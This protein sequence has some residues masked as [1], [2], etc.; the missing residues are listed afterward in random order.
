M[1]PEAQ[2]VKAA[3]EQPDTEKPE[4]TDP[5]KLGADDD[6]NDKTEAGPD[7]LAPGPAAD[8]KTTKT[9]KND[10]IDERKKKKM[11]KSGGEGDRQENPEEEMPSD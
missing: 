8:D 10:V 4:E 9:N 11:K 5:L 2:E 3:E 1:E 7:K 6:D